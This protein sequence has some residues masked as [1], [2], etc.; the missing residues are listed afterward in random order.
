MDKS[1]QVA[2]IP[3]D[4]AEPQYMYECRGVFWGAIPYKRISKPKQ[5]SP[6]TSVEMVYSDVDVVTVQTALEHSTAATTLSIYSRAFNSAQTRAM[7][8][9]AN[10]IDL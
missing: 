4:S 6:G 3:L 1:K 10:V 7:E 9:V 2:P 8:A 5:Y